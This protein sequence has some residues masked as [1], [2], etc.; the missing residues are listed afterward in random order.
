M[1]KK[2]LSAALS[3]MMVMS[4]SVASYAAQFSDV[5]EGAWYHD[6]VERMV[7]H[8][9]VNGYPDGTFRPDGLITVAEFT[10]L[11]V[12]IADSS[13]TLTAAEG[14]K[15]YK[16]YMEKAT[17]LG[18]LPPGIT[19][20]DAEKNITRE[21]MAG[22]CELTARKVF[23]EESINNTTLTELVKGKITDYDTIGNAYGASAGEYKD[24]FIDAY[25]RGFVTGMT[26]TTFEPAGN[27]TRAQATTIIERLADRGSR[28]D[29][30]AELGAEELPKVTDL[31]GVY[32]DSIYA[33]LDSLYNTRTYSDRQLSFTAPAADV[34]TFKD[35]DEYTMVGTNADG[36]TVIEY[37]TLD[38]GT[39]K[40]VE[41][42]PAITVCGVVPG[43]TL[44]SAV[45]N[46]KAE[47]F[48]AAEGADYSENTFTKTA[49]VCDKG[50]DWYVAHLEMDGDAVKTVTLGISSDYAC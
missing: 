26:E 9:V 44:E 39:L 36:K 4:M 43:Q 40:Y 35:A 1:K 21:N 41:A 8:G 29:A 27:A 49:Y 11:A 18:I 20:A 19:M 22:I 32:M 28:V 3:A 23:Q 33:Y 45:K 37:D 16:P 13:Q 30:V 46:L 38:L 7:T 42:D 31:G 47:G 6:V 34:V 14:E 12:T 25:L 2:L 15:W 10:K 50:T 17:A 5:Q 48:V 24:L